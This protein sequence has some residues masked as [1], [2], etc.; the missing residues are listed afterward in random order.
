[1]IFE[2]F[3]YTGIDWQT[4]LE[5]QSHKGMD[6]LTFEGGGGMILCEHDFFSFVAFGQDIFSSLGGVQ[7]IFFSCMYLCRIFL[8]PYY[9]KYKVNNF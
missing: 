6:H 7:D 8:L 3:A 2:S 5:Q 1:M 4:R 9:K